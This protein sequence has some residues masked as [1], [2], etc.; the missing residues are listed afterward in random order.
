MLRAQPGVDSVTHLG[1]HR[2]PR[3]YLPLDQI[4]PQTNVSQFV[5]LPKDL[6]QRETL[7]AQAA[8][9]LSQTNSP[10]CAAA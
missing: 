8:E 4:F 3:F 5:V 7:R 10:R 1:R 9:L 6:K 2:R